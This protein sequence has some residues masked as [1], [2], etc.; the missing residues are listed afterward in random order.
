MKI[1]CMEDIP[2]IE[3]EKIKQV[4]EEIM[5]AIWRMMYLRDGVLDDLGQRQRSFGT[6]WD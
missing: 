5:H 4:K 1:L 2:K 6:E 3:F